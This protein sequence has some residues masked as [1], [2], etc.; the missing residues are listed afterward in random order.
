[1]SKVQE[2]VSLIKK[3]RDVGATGGLRLH[4]FISNSK[5]FMESI[6]SVDCAK[7]VQDS[8]LWKGPLPVE[9]ADSF[10]FLITLKDKPFTRRGLLATVNSVYDPLGFIAPVI[11]VGKIILQDMCRDHADWVDILPDSLKSCWEKWQT[12]PFT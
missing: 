6:P 4:K 1:M 7:G 12:V 2:A 9:R 5:E 11:L 10:S 8:E 3:A